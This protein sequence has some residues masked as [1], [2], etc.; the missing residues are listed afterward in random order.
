MRFEDDKIDRIISE[1]IAK[2]QDN[3]R[4][5]Q[6]NE[7]L[8]QSQVEDKIE[9][10]IKT[11]KFEKKVNNIVADVLSD[12]IESMWTKKAFWKNLIKRK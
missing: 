1:E 3:Q 9:D 10:F 12:F 7:N 4:K 8:T 5:R 11:K 2:I 6:I